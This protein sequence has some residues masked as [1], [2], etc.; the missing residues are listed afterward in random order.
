MKSRDFETIKNIDDNNRKESLKSIVDPLNGQYLND[1]RI[2][3]DYT[4]DE[5]NVGI[6]VKT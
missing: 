1:S 2:T 5:N 6:P 3:S 4:G